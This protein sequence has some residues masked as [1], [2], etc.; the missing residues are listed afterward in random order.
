MGI[1]R[2]GHRQYG[3]DPLNLNL[4]APFSPGSDCH[5]IFPCNISDK[6]IREDMGMKDVVTKINSRDILT[7]SSHYFC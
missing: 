5:Y 7:T 4:L 1:T 2:S 6:L 3:D